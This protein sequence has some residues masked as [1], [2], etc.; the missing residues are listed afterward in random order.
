MITT[1]NK[2][3]KN[4]P[5]SCGALRLFCIRVQNTAS[6][7]CG[8]VSLK[9]SCLPHRTT[10]SR[11]ALQS[12]VTLALLTRLSAV[13][14]PLLVLAR[15]MSSS[16]NV[17]G[18]ADPVQRELMRER[19][20]LVS[21]ADAVVGDAS[22]EHAH[23]IS[24]GLPLHRAFSVILF[25]NIN[26]MLVQKR[27]AEK[28]TF[29]SFWANACCSHPLF[30][31]AELGY[32]DA[33]ETAPMDALPI[34]SICEKETIDA[35]QPEQGCT[36]N[37]SS[38]SFSPSPSPA[39]VKSKPDPILG[40]KRAAVRKLVHELGL[41]PGM[42]TVSDLHFMARIHYRAEC[43]DGVWGEHELDY[44]LLAQLPWHAK[45][46]PNRNEVQATQFMTATEVRDL[47]LL[48]DQYAASPDTNPPVYVSQWFRTIMTS[49]GFTWWRELVEGIN[50]VK[51]ANS[52]A[53]VP[54]PDGPIHA[55]GGCS[56]AAGRTMDMYGNKLPTQSIYGE[57]PHRIDHNASCSWCLREP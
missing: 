54:G 11:C 55:F 21:P 40:V 6:R 37:S 15:G 32:G 49:M 23:S 44:V 33:V 46:D 50:L 18:A 12:P 1:C 20:I 47:F 52:Y 31:D 27:A 34:L 39:P 3:G 45:L 19:V 26:R 10:P 30:T 7:P 4:F 14:S 36:G 17:L 22:K 51:L 29:P 53:D 9:Q 43:D 56:P 42:V 5:D 38:S 48:A 24:H 57:Q 13:Q 25:D 8:V 41:A 16:A 35:P 2:T 28:V